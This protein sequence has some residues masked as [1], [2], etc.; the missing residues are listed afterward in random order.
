MRNAVL[1]GLVIMILALCGGLAVV[2]IAKVRDAAERTQCTNNLKIIGFSILN[3]HDQ[4]KEFPRATMPNPALPPEE[5]FSWQ[6]S[7]VPYIE[8]NP[9]YSE[10]DL[11]QGW[12]CDANRFAAL[13]DC[14]IFRCPE[15][16][17][18]APR[19]T[20][21]PTTYVGLAGLGPD[22]VGLPLENPRTGFFGERQLQVKDLG[23]RSGTL[24]MVV[25]TARVQSAWT[26]GGPAT[27]RG[28][29]AEDPP[30][31]G[32]QGQFGGIHRRGA[33][34]LFADASVRFL[35]ESIEP[36]VWEALATIQGSAPAIPESY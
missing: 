25:E 3:Y 16:R 29:D 26:A 30:Y 31:V 32:V 33:N 13:L 20:L 11:K 21:M 24:L 2:G 15:F 9:F 10:L 12:D 19:S 22:A 4:L 5:R 27:V 1:A 23:G 17:E 8:S 28:I 7:I 18:P 34:V 6:V 14:K 36:G 35:G